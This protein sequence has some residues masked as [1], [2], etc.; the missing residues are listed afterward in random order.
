MSSTAQRNTT[1]RSSEPD[2]TYLIQPKQ[3]R[4]KHVIVALLL[5]VVFFFLFCFIALH[6]YI[7]WVLSYP[8]VASVYSNPMQAKNMAYEDITFPA[9]DGSR[10]M[11]GWYIP[12]EKHSTKTII[13]SHGYGA[14]REET[15][16][17]MYDL[18][19][20]AHRLNFNVIMFD[21]GFASKTN[22]EVAT[23]GKKESQQLLGA[24][25]LAKQRGAQELVVWGFS[26]G[27]GTALQAGLLTDQVD[28]M[29]LDSTFLLEP[30]TLYY[31]IRQQMALPQHPSIEIL[32][33]LLPV[34][35]GTSLNQIPYQT[36]KKKDYPFPIF[37]I[38]GTQDSKAPYQIAEQLASNQTNPDSE[39]WIIPGA[40]HELEF[41]E[42]PREY[43]RYVSN[44]LSNLDLATGDEMDT[45]P[46]LNGTTEDSGLNSGATK[47]SPP[48]PASEA[49]KS[50][51][52]AKD[53]TDAADSDTT[54]SRSNGTTES[55]KSTES[56]EKDSTSQNTDPSTESTP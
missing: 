16:I 27:A 37:F 55:T 26:M 31:N 39:V 30:D 54:R 15:W 17:P 24:I 8:T 21:Y 44:F 38:H 12:A 34:V 14:N 36:V 28:A 43:L 18:A 49:G 7:A 2:E 35:N 40:H 13:F 42:H 48:I 53:S 25:D 3:V 5:S 47:P 46:M 9:H 56:K 1:P 4:L 19:H 51:N 22:P 32:E 10:M 45:D 41:R 11:Q 20:Y 23:G 52:K 50:S 29:I 33:T 6:A